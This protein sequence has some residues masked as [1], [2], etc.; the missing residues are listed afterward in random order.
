MFEK[1]IRLLKTMTLKN[2]PCHVSR[3]QRYDYAVEFSNQGNKGSEVCQV[4]PLVTCVKWI[5]KNRK[6]LSTEFKIIP[7]LILI[8]Y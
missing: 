7:N 3:W 5:K 6:K 8:K 1:H 4:G 2:K